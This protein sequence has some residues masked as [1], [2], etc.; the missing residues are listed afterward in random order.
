M[1]SS[2]TNNNDNG[3]MDHKFVLENNHTASVGFGRNGLLNLLRSCCFFF[4]ASSIF[5]RLGLYSMT[6]RPIC[7]TATDPVASSNCL[8]TSGISPGQLLCTLSCWHN[9][10]EYEQPTYVG[11]IT[12]E[13][14]KINLHRKLSSVKLRESGS[15]NVKT[16]IL[17]IKCSYLIPPT[18]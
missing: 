4:S 15:C 17:I 5:L 10:K 18:H 6:D 2:F 8:T 3:Q 7:P 1:T 9:K 16:V 13:G 14:S 12:T 11:F